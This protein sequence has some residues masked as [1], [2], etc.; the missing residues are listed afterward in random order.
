MINDIIAITKNALSQNITYHD[1]YTEYERNN[2]SYSTSCYYKISSF[3]KTKLHE[4]YNSGWSVSV[5]DPN[6]YSDSSID[7]KNFFDFYFGRLLFIITK[8]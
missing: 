1:C 2:G 8:Y 6:Y 5:G 3:I 7:E 4:K